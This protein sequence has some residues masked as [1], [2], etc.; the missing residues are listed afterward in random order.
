MSFKIV[1]GKSGSGKSTYC[2]NDIKSKINSA[3]KIFIIVPEQF[4]FTAEKNLVDLFENKSTINAEVLTL[5]RMAYRVIS[6]VGND[7]KISLSKSSKSMIIYDILLSEKENLKF[8]GKTDKNL[9]LLERTFTELKK[10]NITAETLDSINIENEYLKNKI[11][12][13]KNI[14]EKYT[15]RIS[16]EYIDENDSLTIL[17][18]KLDE[19]DMFKNSN[20]YIDEFIGFTPQE[21]LVIEKLMKRA[22]MLTVTV[23]TDGL[24][25]DKPK[26]ND[27]FYF[28]KLTAQKLIEIAN[29]NNIKIENEIYLK[30]NLRTKKEELKFIE[31]NLYSINS[32]VYEKENEAV[33][34]FL[35][36]NPYSEMEYVAK[37]IVK[38]V[39]EKNYRYK[40]IGI[41]TKNIDSYSS[42]AKAIFEKYD[43]PLFIDEKKDLSNNILVKYIVA[44]LDVFAKNWSYESMFNYIKTG[45]L[46]IDKEYLFEL[47]EYC[48][49]WGIKGA[50]WYKADWTYEPINLSQ[51]ILNDIRLQIINPLIKFKKSLSTEK[52]GYEITKALY[53]FL[54]ENKITE[55]ISDKIEKLDNV[56]LQNEY[57]TCY[58]TIINLFDE[59]A[60]IF[61]DDVM[62]FEKYMSLLLV[63]LSE[64]GIGK[65]PATQDQVIM[66]D[67][68]RSKSHALKLV[69]IVGV[70]DGSFPS[71][72]KD[73]GFLSD[74]DRE[75]LKEQ[76]LEMAKTTMDMVYEEQFN[77]YKTLT[78]PTE[79][80]YISYTSS[81]NSNK[82]LRPSILIKKIKKIFPN[83]LED[84]DILEKEYIMVNKKSTLED[85]LNVYKNYLNGEEISEEWKN[86]LAYFNKIQDQR[87]IK[88]IKGIKYTNLPEKIKKEN[89]EKL[90][91]KT[92]TTSVSKLEQY[93]KC[94]FS[95]H[96]KY[97]LKLQE[98]AEFSLDSV[99]T[100]SFMHDVIDR[101]FEKLDE[102]QISVKNIEDDTIKKVVGNVIEEI[103]GMS[104]YYKLSSTPKFRIL[105]ARLKKVVI[106]SIEFIVKSL[107]QSDFEIFGHEVEFNFKTK[108]KPIEIDL[109]DGRKVEVIGKIDRMDVGK[110]DSKKYVRIIDYKSSIK[111]IDFNQVMAGI[112]IQLI[113]YLDATKKIDD[114]SDAG[115]LYFSLID[116]VIKAK[117][118]LSEEEIENEIKKKFK[119]QGIL[120]ANVNVVKAMD[121]KLDKGYSE[122]IPAYIDKEGNL[123]EKSSSTIKEEDFTNLQKQVKKIIKDISKEILDGKI[124][125]KPYYY[126]KKTACDYCSYKTICYFNTNIKGNEFNY[127]NKFDKQYMLNKIK[128]DLKKDETM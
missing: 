43:I 60:S 100:G 1:Y 128:E 106:K 48:K 40:E 86:V 122:I 61:K 14:Y 74:S 47:E 2:Y 4:S 55:T 32:S 121:N 15:E 50:K 46:N 31:E 78:I 8:L 64:S 16:S 102:M 110:I 38:F 91:G 13:I 117:K 35:S 27:I 44:L 82:S 67:V 3:E 28:N 41:I 79:Y 125:I 57:A 65:I 126:N 7:N 21:Y 34:I 56:E 30:E 116:T 77:I 36:N 59:I 94:P 72:S 42:N 11:T 26:E 99:D 70:N 123:S 9:E 96:L 127:I 24:N 109:D 98:K 17:A 120:V 97:G 19:T 12:D 111:N 118:N 69:F 6:E 107:Q 39:R 81:D 93:R 108:Y 37:N 10:H 95:F 54:V 51:Q 45:L 63:G 90:Y 66:G 22:S 25:V 84:S 75:I 52:T 105:T 68:D 114:F 85:S 23:C 33:K 20:I 83:I 62:S 104:R 124:D 49:K 29:L 115:I 101:F 88:S 73:E 113:T 87:F 71:V 53:E 103:L 76:G 112:Q 92:I 80:L 5:S 58:N 89:I 18:E 119:M